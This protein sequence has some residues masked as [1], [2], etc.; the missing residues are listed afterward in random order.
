MTQTASSSELASPRPPTVAE[1]ITRLVPY[2]P[3]KPIEEVERELGITNIVKLA[4][5]E[6]SLGPSPRAIQAMHDFAVKMHLYPDAS[7]YNLRRA[8]AA[9]LSVP[10]ETLV[11]GNGSD[12]IIHLLGVTFLSPGD[13]VIQA[14][15]TF[16]R[17]EAAAILHNAPCHL[18]P[19]TADWAHDLEAMAAKINANT[20]LI[21]ICNPNNPT[22]TIVTREALDRFLARVPERVLVV[23]DEAYYEYAA[24]AADYPDSLRY[25]HEGRNVVVLR[26]FSKAY[27]LAGLR[28]GYGVMRPEIAHWLDRT[29]EPFNVNSMAQAAALAALE[30]TEHVRRTLAM[31]AAGKRD[32]YAAFDALSL[33]YAPTYANFVWVDVQQDSKAVFQALLCKGVITRTGDVFNAP[34]H[35]RV[36]IGTE[37]ENAKFLTALREVL[38]ESS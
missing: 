14:W 15:P 29:R 18:V 31:N 2:R 22:G 19:L 10:E 36:T 38:T 11:F 1:H 34:T 5:N 13:E 27:G 30:D 23:L 8:V 26:T 21:F 33:P 7:N 20:R 24:D 4:S 37:E 3:G 17:Y 35:L 9:H 28:I 16:V 12:D 32:F 25:V 6:N